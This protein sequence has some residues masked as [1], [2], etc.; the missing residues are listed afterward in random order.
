MRGGLTDQGARSTECIVEP[1]LLW[2]PNLHQS[3]SNLRNVLAI[4]SS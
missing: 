1:P 3:V 2:P 4:Q